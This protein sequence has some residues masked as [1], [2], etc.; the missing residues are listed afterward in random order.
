MPYQEDYIRKDTTIV[1]LK[2]TKEALDIYRADGETWNAFILKVI[3]LLE[4]EASKDI[5][6]LSYNIS[7]NKSKNLSG[8][9]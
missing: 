6:P 1:V 5:D 4:I 9:L 8:N 2:Q 7:L 3:A